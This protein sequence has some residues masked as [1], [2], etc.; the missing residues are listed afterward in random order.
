MDKNFKVEEILH[1]INLCSSL[2]IGDLKTNCDCKS[3]TEGQ[4]DFEIHDEKCSVKSYCSKEASDILVSREATN[5]LVLVIVGDKSYDYE[6]IGSVIGFNSHFIA[7]KKVENNHELS[8]LYDNQR[9]NQVILIDWEESLKHIDS[10]H[11]GFYKQRGKKYYIIHF[12]I[13]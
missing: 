1:S 11:F 6:R 10:E 9:E 8:L 13:F 3:N 2:K 12:F 4:E 5:D 7:L